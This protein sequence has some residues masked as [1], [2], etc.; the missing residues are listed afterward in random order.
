M[1]LLTAV[2]VYS[3]FVC[4][5]PCIHLSMRLFICNLGNP[6]EFRQMSDKSLH[7]TAMAH[8]EHKS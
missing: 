1:H 2:S 4:V 6:K 7:R 3:A 5:R 8:V